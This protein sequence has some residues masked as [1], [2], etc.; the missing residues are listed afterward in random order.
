VRLGGRSFATGGFDGRLHGRRRVEHVAR[1]GGSYVLRLP[2]AS[3]AL[4][5]A[6]R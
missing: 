3:A 1:R 6:R 4:V 2:P 5:T